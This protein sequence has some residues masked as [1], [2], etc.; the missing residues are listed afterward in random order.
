MVA[1]TLNDDLNNMAFDENRFEYVD[2]RID[3]LKTLFRKYGG[4]YD[5]LMAYFGEISA[6]LDNLINS[7]AK[8]D[9]LVANKEDVL[10]EIDI[11]QNRLHE[12]RVKN[13]KKLQSELEKELKI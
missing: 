9:A 7:S 5:S 10:T 11:I 3:F 1:D 4:N 8:Y 6:K 12:E 2:K 13:A